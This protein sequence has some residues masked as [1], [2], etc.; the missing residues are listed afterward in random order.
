MTKQQAVKAVSSVFN[1]IYRVISTA[2]VTLAV[3]L[4]ILYLC[5][6]R[7]YHVKSGSMGELLPVG[8]M[9]FVNT[10]TPYDSIRTGDVISFRVS[11]DM[12]VTHRAVR[13][14]EDGIVTRG[15]ENDTEDPD[16]VTQENYIGKTVFALPYVGRML[17]GLHTLPGKIML[18]AA[19]VVLLLSGIVYRRINEE[20]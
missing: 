16:P 6:I 10:K 18:A 5:G 14:T 11:E 15:D 1:L 20:S 4:G 9:C 13:I 19:V 3:L 17:G 12:R 7:L 8:C 2:V